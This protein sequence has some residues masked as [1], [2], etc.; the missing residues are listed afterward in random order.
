MN[1]DVLAIGAHP[2]DVE[3]GVGGIIAKMTR[4]GFRVAI[5]DLTQGELGTRGTAQE[6]AGE[7][8]EAARLLGVAVRQNA[9][10]RD[11][12][13]QNDETQRS[14]VVRFVREFRP[15]LLL[16]PMSP[17]R[18]PDHAAAHE[19]VRDANYLAGLKKLEAGGE[20]YRAPV[21]YFYHPYEGP[22]NAAA[23]VVDVSD[24]FDEKL[25]ALRAYASQFHNPNYQADAT[26]IASREFWD[27]I[28]ARARV[29]GARIGV[30]YGE[31]LYSLG[32]V[33]VGLPPGL[34]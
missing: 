25:A 27:S 33:G 14:I 18:H 17:D 13:L 19:L 29:W 3:L 9:G 7:A 11:G 23:L 15:R 4:Q 1:V 16:A 30:Q 22:G 24:T 26:W 31:P 12:F 6:R 34:T 20:P 28:A 2:D 5:L 8:G 10:L 21:A 32:P